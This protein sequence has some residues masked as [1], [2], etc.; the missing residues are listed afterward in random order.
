MI[1]RDVDMTGY[2]KKCGFIVAGPN[3][4]VENRQ[5]LGGSTVNDFMTKARRVIRGS[6]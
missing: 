2:I 5:S 1:M 4:E 3:V 6:L